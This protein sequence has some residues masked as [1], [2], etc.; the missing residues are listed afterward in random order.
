VSELDDG[1]QIS[2]AFLKGYEAGV[3]EEQ[4][5]IIALIKD[6]AAKRDILEA[7]ADPYYAKD[8]EKLIR[9]G[10]DD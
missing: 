1:L 5:R 6:K 4:K 7:L 8:L 9:E 10:Q 2:F 3:E